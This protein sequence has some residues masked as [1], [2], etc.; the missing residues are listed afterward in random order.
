MRAPRS[1]SSSQTNLLIKITLIFFLMA[2]WIAGTQAAEVQLS[3]KA[4]MGG[5]KLDFKMTLSDSQQFI[6]QIDGYQS[7]LTGF[8]G[9]SFWR[10]E[11][12]VGPLEIDF[13]EKEIW[14]AI[15]WILS[16][17][18]LQEDAPLDWQSDPKTGNAI[19]TLQGGQLQLLT[20]IS[21]AKIKASKSAKLNIKQAVNQNPLPTKITVINLPQELT[22]SF[23]GRQ[24]L[25]GLS[26]PQKVTIIGIGQVESFEIQQAQIMRPSL[27]SNSPRDRLAK[28]ERPLY[29]AKNTNFDLTESPEI[30]IKQAKSGHIF[31]KPLINGEQVG[32]FLFDSGAGSSMLTQELI[33]KFDFERVANTVTGG[34]GGIAGYYDIYHGGELKLG[35]LSIKDLNYKV[36][37]PN[38]SMASK[39][40]GEPVVGVLGWDILTRSK[41]NLSIS[42]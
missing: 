29:R 34:I 27:T 15:H 42:S 36:Y 19:F 11:N 16:G 32:W 2:I 28:F 41:S 6:N 13:S 35:P 20:D 30:T 3:G 17:Y 24:Q 22:V 1:T 40:L 14:I 23:S 8:D 5:E 31:V 26:L 4:E 37:N 18:W 39:I 7:M 25:S 12:G 21:L 9:Q 10:I 38:R 33:D